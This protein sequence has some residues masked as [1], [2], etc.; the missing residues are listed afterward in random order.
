MVKIV[1]ESQWVV[2]DLSQQVF[3][4]WNWCSFFCCTLL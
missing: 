1:F 3:G 4:W 2:I